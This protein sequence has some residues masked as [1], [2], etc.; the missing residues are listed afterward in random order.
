MAGES[1]KKASN[2]LAKG[3][4]IKVAYRDPMG[5][6]DPV[7]RGESA[8]SVGTVDTYSYNE[9]EPTSVEWIREITP[10]F[11]QFVNYLISLFPFLNWIGR[12]NLQW[13]LGDLVAG[14][15]VGAVVIPQGM[16]Y[17]KLAEVPV[18]FGLY[19]SFMGVLVYWFFATSKDITIGVSWNLPQTTIWMRSINLVSFDSPWLLCL[20]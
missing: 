8:F 1:F 17:A 2:A 13:F 4:G 7:T 18:Q 15:T 5:A 14:V 16:A 9:P 11:H 19:S 6:N 12:Y 3:L 10:S 20:H